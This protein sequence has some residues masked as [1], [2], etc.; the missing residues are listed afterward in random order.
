MHAHYDYIIAGGGGSGLSLLRT[1]LCHER[2][3]HK[4]I[5][6]IDRE[7]KLQN[8][9][10]WCFWATPEELAAYNLP[11]QHEWE[12]LSFIT[13]EQQVTHSIHPYRYY[14]LRSGAFYEAAREEA[15]AFPNVTFLQT[16][17]EDIC[18]HPERPQL[19]SEDGIFSAD[20][21]FSSLADTNAIRDK[22]TYFLSQRFLG[23]FVRAPYPVFDTRAVRFMDFR[24]SQDQGTQF[25]YVL[26]FSQTE[27]LIEST[28]FVPSGS[29]TPDFQ[30]Q[31]RSY[32]QQ[33]YDL[34]EYE[35]SETE[36][37]NIPMSSYDFG[38]PRSSRI[39]PI[40]T[41]GGCTKSSTGYTFKTIQQHS[42]QIVNQL[43]NGKHPTPW[44][45][46][47]RFRFYDRVLLHLLQERGQN[48]GKKIFT[49]LLGE[50]EL[51]HVLRFL[52]EKTHP[53]QELALFLHLPWGMFLK[54]A[55]TTWKRS[56][57]PE[58]T[59]LHEPQTTLLPS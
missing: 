25:F 52:E 7:F 48:A 1:L 35:I 46:N 44:Q 57:Q 33:Y 29:A 16:T 36:S 15:R 5:L 40:G 41:A 38:R 8:D 54:A 58:K 10:T 37:G 3:R 21:I 55:A 9:R 26:P 34:N 39:V 14:C 20:F 19:V 12:H 23:W 22:S 13:D 27:A 51:P 59:T 2:L 50:G 30:P 56:L 32:L 47:S 4:R 11:V 42:H 18:E 24:I 28:A 43:E 17:I 45:R 53:L 6:V 31:L 49:P